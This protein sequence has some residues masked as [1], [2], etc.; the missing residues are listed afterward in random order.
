L[1][2]WA[3]GSGSVAESARE[4]EAAAEDAAEDVAAPLT[5]SA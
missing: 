1:R 4:R 3:A 2:I 5:F